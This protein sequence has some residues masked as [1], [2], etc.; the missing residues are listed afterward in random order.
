MVF[1]SGSSADFEGLLA[2]NRE[3]CAQITAKKTLAKG[4]GNKSG[5]P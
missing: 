3:S 5:F 4:R 1:L 2:L